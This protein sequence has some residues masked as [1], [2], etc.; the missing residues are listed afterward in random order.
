MWKERDSQKAC[1]TSLLPRDA[2][3]NYA[4]IRTRERLSVASV[5][6]YRE[7][8]RGY[9]YVRGVR[10]SKLCRTKGEA[11][12]WA[13]RRETD[14]KTQNKGSLVPFKDYEP[15][16]QEELQTL[17]E[18]SVMTRHSGVYFLWNGRGQ[19]V[20]IGQSRDVGKRIAMHTK[21][22]PAEFSTARYIK[23]GHPWQLAIERLYIDKYMGEILSD[24]SGVCLANCS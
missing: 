2:G 22:P 19:L 23:V 3:Y 7:G 24:G 21:K 11:Q 16:T 10:E 1:N 17:P 12:R 15:L 14:N 9:V 8:W 20:Y 13:E 5:C 18:V 4:Q 6:R